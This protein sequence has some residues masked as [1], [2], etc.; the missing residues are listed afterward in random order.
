VR[1][2]V[3]GVIH[4]LDPASE[5]ADPAESVTRATVLPLV[6]E[7]LVRVDAVAG[8]Q[9]LLAESWQSEAQDRRWHFRLRRRVALHDGKELTPADVATAL[10]AFNAA[11]TVKET[12]DGV[13]IESPEPM[14]DLAWALADPR[15]AIAITRPAGLP[16]GTGPFRVDRWEPGRRLV[17]A[18][19]EGYRDGRP[20]VD[21]VQI[22]M[23]RALGDE[24]ASLELG[25]ADIVSLLPQD[26]R[27][28]SER[29]LRVATSRPRELVALVFDA[30]RPAASNEQVRTAVA[31]AIDR[32]TICTVLMQRQGEV[33]TALVPDWLSGYASIFFARFDRG[34]ARSIVASLPLARRTVLLQ[35]PASD[36]VALAVADR[37]AVDVREVGLT[38]KV[39]PSSAIGGP[40]P[41]VRLV[42]V[43]L[44]V[45]TP[46]RALAAL[47]TPLGLDATGL[48][49]PGSPLETAS[50]FEQA[51][52]ESNLAVPLVH[53]PQIHGLSPRLERSNGPIVT[54]AGSLNLADAWLRGGTP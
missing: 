51:L 46:E 10:R 18:A 53:V 4:A 42:H 5:S 44:D 50:R 20:F 48:P 33:A 38:L 34:A 54:P 12:G 22:E 27:R 19:Q 30:R 52:L 7:T 47:V 41:D 37:V 23:G 21:G 8:L 49:D 24:V 6:F 35:Y 17:L 29:H 11:W 39:A 13:Q 14:P 28:V 15:R 25:R 2:E 36:A 32:A 31:L 40:P 45:T 3:P 1:I 43:T 26:V 16:V 9:P